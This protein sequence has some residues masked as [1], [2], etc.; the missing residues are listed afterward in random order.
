MKKLLFSFLPILLTFVTYPVV[1]IPLITP[2]MAQE[3][4]LRT[5]TVTGKGTVRIPTTLTDVSLGVEIQGKTAAEVQQNVAQRT[6]SLV[7]FLRS[8]QVER[9]ETTGIRLQPNYQYD[10]NQRR[11]V[12]YIGTNIVSFRVKTEEVGSLLDDAVKAGATRIDRVSFSATETAISA[13]QKEALKLATMDAQAQAEAVLSTLNFQSQEIIS[14]SINGANEPQPQII[15]SPESL[16]TASAADS[17]PVIGGE[18]NIE[19]MVTLQMRY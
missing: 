13:A 6:S 9:L 10:N 2:A 8:R 19:A 16:R 5:L 12:G 11:L 15:Q 1:S 7:D 4:V 17:T 3:Q 14:I 18:Q